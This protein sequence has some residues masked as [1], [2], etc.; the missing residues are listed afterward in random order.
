VTAWHATLYLN[1]AL[2]EQQTVDLAGGARIAGVLS[3]AD[4]RATQVHVKLTSQAWDRA[5]LEIRDRTRVIEQMTGRSVMHLVLAKEAVS[6][7]GVGL[8]GPGEVARML[9]VSRARLRTLRETDPA[10]PAPTLSLGQGDVWTAE[11]IAAYD[12]ARTTMS[13]P[14]AG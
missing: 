10:F 9:A 5:L 14:V 8:V 6:G 4:R 2:T 3:S 12:A 7:G 11:A 13:G 1:G